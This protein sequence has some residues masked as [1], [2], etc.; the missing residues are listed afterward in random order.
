MPTPSSYIY[1]TI[2]SIMA[3]RFVEVVTQAKGATVSAAIRLHMQKK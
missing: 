3:D 1:V 2:L